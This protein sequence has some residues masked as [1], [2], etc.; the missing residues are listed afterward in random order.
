MA[1]TAEHWTGDLV[2][3]RGHVLGLPHLAAFAASKPLQEAFYTAAQRLLAQPDNDPSQ[4][5]LHLHAVLVSAPNGNF[6][7]LL[8]RL[9][10]DAV[11]LCRKKR[12][13]LRLQSFVTDAR[14]VPAAILHYMVIMRLVQLS[15]E[16]SVP[17]EVLVEAV[18]RL[19]D[20]TSM[21]SHAAAQLGWQ[22]VVELAPDHSE[23]QEALVRLRERQFAHPD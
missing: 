21:L 3:L 9:L 13:L 7:G 15:K 12:Q 1:A 4:E 10:C 14:P 16:K 20:P 22:R 23:A 5:A 6:T 18:R 19:P 8:T 17:V 2:P 11:R